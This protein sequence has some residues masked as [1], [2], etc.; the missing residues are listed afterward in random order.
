LDSVKWLCA[1]VNATFSTCGGHS[2]E[3]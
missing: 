3:A 2:D 1:L